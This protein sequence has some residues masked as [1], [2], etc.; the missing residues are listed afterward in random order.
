[1]TVLATDEPMVTCKTSDLGFAA[2]MRANGL[3]LDHV[4]I[5]GK[6]RAEFHFR[7]PVKKFPDLN[8]SYFNSAEKRF[9][10]EVRA[11]KKLVS[12]VH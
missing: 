4:E 3:V 10:D 5:V 12:R 11:L 7:D 2:Y 9:D 1:M 8:L 6:N